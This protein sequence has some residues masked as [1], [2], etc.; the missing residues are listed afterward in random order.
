MMLALKSLLSAADQT[1]ALIFDEIDAGIGGRVGTVVG[2]KLAG[3]AREHQVICVTHLPQLA[4][5]TD[6]HFRVTKAEQASRTIT[7]VESLDESGQIEELALML[8][9]AG[10]AARHTAQELLRRAR[11]T[12]EATPA[13]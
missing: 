6:F 3:L 12:T 2:R 8:G 7:Q 11:G 5:F 1:P 13:S 9:G 4:A 10:E